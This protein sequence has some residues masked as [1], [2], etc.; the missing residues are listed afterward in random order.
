[1]HIYCT[2]NIDSKMRHSFNCVYTF[3]AL[4]AFP[5]RFVA[6]NIA[7][8]KTNSSS[9]KCYKQGIMKQFQSRIGRFVIYP[10]NIFKDYYQKKLKNDQCKSYLGPPYRQFTKQICQ[11]ERICVRV[12]RHQGSLETVCSNQFHG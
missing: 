10:K 5:H 1:M 3:I 6:N 2:N 11:G 9:L 12:R 8:Y 4:I 7:I